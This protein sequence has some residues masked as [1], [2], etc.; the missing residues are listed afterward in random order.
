MRPIKENGYTKYLTVER[1]VNAATEP[2]HT[3]LDRQSKGM[4][5]WAMPLL[6]IAIGMLAALLFTGC[7]HSKTTGTVDP[8]TGG[9]VFNTST[10]AFGNRA[11]ENSK[12]MEFLA[13]KT[14]NS[15]HVEGSGQGDMK[16]D[17]S[18]DMMKA[19]GAFFG[20]TISNGQE[21]E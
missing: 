6:W 9:I 15:F 20:A 8:V 21:V 12:S 3:R 13:E 10:T 11:I 19:L 4:M 1:A 18:T 16:A 7:A 2:R 17:Q 14:P 5:T